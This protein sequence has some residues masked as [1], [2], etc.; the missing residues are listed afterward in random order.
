MT[1]IE[2]F[3]EVL[4]E[5]YVWP[6][7]YPF[8]FIIKLEQKEEIINILTGY[9]LSFRESKTGK[10]LSVNFEINAQSSEEIINIYD[11]ISIMDNVIKI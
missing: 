2:R 6:S 5:S 4:D 11:K 9:N 8:K 1:S 3:R 10:Y 7:I